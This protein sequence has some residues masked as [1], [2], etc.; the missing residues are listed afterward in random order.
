[1]MKLSFVRVFEGWKVKIPGDFDNEKNWFSLWKVLLLLSL[2]QSNLSFRLTVSILFYKIASLF[3][4]KVFYTNWVTKRFMLSNCW[5]WSRRWL[6]IS[7]K[8]TLQEMPI[9]DTEKGL[10]F[11]GKIFSLSQIQSFEVKSFNLGNRKH[12]TLSRPKWLKE[13]SK[14]KYPRI[15]S[16]YK[17]HLI[18][19]IGT[20][21]DSIPI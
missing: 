1:M 16:N 13:Y 3:F 6:R 21:F 18:Y 14:K 4:K 10:W 19:I 11:V 15:K 5:R 20:F 2:C 7:N 8:T 17:L 9:I 12:A